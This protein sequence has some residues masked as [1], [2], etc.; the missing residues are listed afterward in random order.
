MKQRLGESPWRLFTA[1]L[2]LFSCAGALAP[3]ALANQQ[4]VQVVL[5]GSTIP[6]FVEPL[7][8]FNGKRADGTQGY[9]LTLTATEFQQQI[10]P[11]SFYASLPNSVAYIDQVTGKV[12]ARINPRNGTYVWGYQINDGVNTFGP[13]APGP[14]RF[15]SASD[16][17]YSMKVIG[18]VLGIPTALAS[19][20][21]SAA[22]PV[23]PCTQ[24]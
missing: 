1:T 21:A 24:I 8:T 16:S 5:A 14:T 4:I 18:T 2:A 10:L 3:P 15:S 13:S 20:I 11:A 7:P 17:V 23:T 12:V 9:T 22:F 6:K 19:L